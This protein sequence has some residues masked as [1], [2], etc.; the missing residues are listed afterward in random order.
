MIALSIVPLSFAGS[1]ATGCER[2][3]RYAPAT[4]HTD[5]RPAILR[6]RRGKVVTHPYVRAVTANVTAPSVTPSHLSLSPADRVVPESPVSL[7]TPPAHLSQHSERQFG[8]NQLPFSTRASAEAMFPPGLEGVTWDM[9]EE[10]NYD[11]ATTIFYPEG[12]RRHPAHRLW[13]A[14]GDRRYVAAPVPSDPVVTP[15]QAA[16]EE[17]EEGE[18]VAP[19]FQAT[20]SPIHAAFHAHVS[21][22]PG[23]HDAERP[24]DYVPRPYAGVGAPGPYDC[25]YSDYYL[26][27]RIRRAIVEFEAKLDDIKALVAVPVS[28]RLRGY[29]MYR[30]YT[31]IP[32]Q[33]LPPIPSP[34]DTPVCSFVDLDS[35]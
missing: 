32:A 29:D 26:H 18:F 34:Q 25:P 33:T 14:Y 5:I 11:T 4:W 21:V 6:R 31:Q 8:D 28:Y 19:Q 1:R 7:L 23:F 27:S 13:G 17:D 3:A 20:P 9:V 15:T 35:L 22:P 16:E 24:S 2:R 12:N 30:Q 10:F